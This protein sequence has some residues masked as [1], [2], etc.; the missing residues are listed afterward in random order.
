MRSKLTFAKIFSTR[1]SLAIIL[2]LLAS[3]DPTAQELRMHVPSWAQFDPE[4][5]PAV[6]EERSY[7]RLVD[8]PE[9][10]G[11][12]SL[13]SIAAGT[14]DLALVENSNAFMPGIRVVLPA[15]VSVLHVLV[16]DDYSPQDHAQPFQDVSFYIPGSS[17]AAISVVNLIAQRQGF[18]PSQYQISDVFIPGKT[19]FILYFGPIDTRN[20]GWYQP[21]FEMVSLR[22]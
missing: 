17:E 18:E 2:T 14:A 7:I 8:A 22:R 4:S 6:F 1:F 21:G 12:S 11:Q 10:R 16:R 19:D 13:Q 15:F 5:I 9:A 20:L 3:C